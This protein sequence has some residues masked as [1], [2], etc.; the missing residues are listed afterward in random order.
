MICSERELVVVT[1]YHQCQQYRILSI[2]GAEVVPE[3]AVNRWDEYLFFLLLFYWWF[4]FFSFWVLAFFT[5]FNFLFRR[6]SWWLN[7]LLFLWWLGRIIFGVLLWSDRSSIV[8]EDFVEA[9]LLVIVLNNVLSSHSIC[10][11]VIGLD[12]VKLARVFLL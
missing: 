10:G 1:L 9:Y 11:V 6:R 7:L 5:L 2:V 4:G 3:G 8:L 12:N